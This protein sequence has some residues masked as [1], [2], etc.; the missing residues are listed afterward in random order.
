MKWIDT[1]SLPETF[2][3][4]RFKLSKISSGTPAD[5]PESRRKD[6]RRGALRDRVMACN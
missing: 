5:L 2:H 1:G 6:G 4:H 3:H